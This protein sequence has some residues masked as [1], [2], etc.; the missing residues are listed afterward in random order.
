MICDARMPKPVR[1]AADRVIQGLLLVGGAGVY[2]VG[3]G[4]AVLAAAL[5]RARGFAV[6]EAGPALTI[7]GAGAILALSLRADALVDATTYA[8]AVGAVG[9]V[10][11]A[12]GV[13]RLAA[14]RSP[15]EPA[16]SG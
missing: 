1:T 15:A 9:V 14:R 11:V 8:I 16:E 13:W 6:S 12:G 4:L 3:V 10:N 7:V 5:L 2:L